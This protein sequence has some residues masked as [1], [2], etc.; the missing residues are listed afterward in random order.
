MNSAELEQLIARIERLPDGEIIKALASPGD[1]TLAAATIYESEA[2]RRGI[3][4]EAVRPVAIREAQR[5]RD[6][7]G[8]AWSFKGIGEKLYGMR[9]FRADESY[10]TTKWFVFLHLPIYPVSSL[11][12]RPDGTGK[13]SVLEV[14]PIDWRQVLDTYCFVAIA[15][16]SVAMG[17]RWLEKAELPFS[18]VASVALLGLP[19]LFLYLLR[20]R[21][22]RGMPRSE[23]AENVPNKTLEPTRRS[24]TRPAMHERSEA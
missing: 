7:E 21:A 20:R 10:Q 22:R 23:A 16:G 9:S 4:P 11:R 13:I 3:R 14:L 24:V 1:F 18:E 15:W 5:K 12:V 6:K 8:V 19:F 2:Q 17:I